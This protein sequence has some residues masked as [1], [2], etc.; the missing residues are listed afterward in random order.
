MNT[1][2]LMCL[3]DQICELI[4]DSFDGMPGAGTCA[5]DIRK[6]ELINKVASLIGQMEATDND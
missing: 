5:W 4:S 1:D 6:M 3:E 2:E